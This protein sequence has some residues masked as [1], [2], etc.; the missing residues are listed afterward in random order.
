MS[1]PNRGEG[2]SLELG[3]A[4]PRESV[5]VMRVSVEAYIRSQSWRLA[6]AMITRTGDPLL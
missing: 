4:G 5:S 3:L 2:G 6:G 1:A